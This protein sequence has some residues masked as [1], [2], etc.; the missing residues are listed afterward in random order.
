M[1]FG[2]F[3]STGLTQQPNS[4]KKMQNCAGKN[5]SASRNSRIP[6][7]PVKMNLT[8][9]FCLASFLHAHEKCAI[10]VAAVPPQ[11]RSHDW[12]WWVRGAARVAS[13]SECH[14]ALYCN[15]KVKC[16]VRTK[17]TFS[18]LQ[19]RDIKTVPSGV[20]RHACSFGTLS[21]SANEKNSS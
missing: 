15:T 1:Y 17:C 7:L 5:K 11:T 21:P 6:E 19:Y 4:P 18:A 12:L 20:T 13:I 8:R 10:P 14:F 2:C 9:P 16:T 3:L